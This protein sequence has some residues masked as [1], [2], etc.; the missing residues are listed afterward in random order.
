MLA[1]PDADDR[2]ARQEWTQ[3]ADDGFHFGQFGHPQ[4]QF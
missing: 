3:I 1:L 4:L 2:A